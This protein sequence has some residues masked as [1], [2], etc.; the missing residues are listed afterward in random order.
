MIT[1]NWKR[2]QL[3]PIS[4]FYTLNVC[5]AYIITAHMTT[6]TLTR[7]ETWNPMLDLQPKSTGR[8]YKQYVYDNTNE[9]HFEELGSFFV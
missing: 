8:L 9:I 2:K 3:K 7:T 5:D 6:I 1:E 4:Q